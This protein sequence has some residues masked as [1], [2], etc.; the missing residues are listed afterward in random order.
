MLAFSH[1][2]KFVETEKLLDRKRPLLQKLAAKKKL[3]DNSK[4]DSINDSRM[5]Q[6]KDLQVVEIASTLHTD[7]FYENAYPFQSVRPSYDQDCDE[8]GSESW[9]GF[10]IFDFWILFDVR[11]K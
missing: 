1:L 4:L 6:H 10:G 3:P 7:T 2:V 9:C 8:E 11:A 5:I